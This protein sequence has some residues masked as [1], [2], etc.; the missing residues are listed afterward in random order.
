MNWMRQFGSLKL[1]IKFTLVIILF[2]VIPIGV[3]ASVL[4]YNM[5]QNVIDEN[6]NYMQYT[7]E[8]NKDALSTKMDS[9]NMST[10]LF[11]SDSALLDILKNTQEGKKYSAEEWYALKS[12]DITSLERLVNNNPLLYGVRVYATND[13]IQEVMPVLYNSS[14]MKKQVWAKADDPSGWHFNYT[15]NLFSSYTMDQNRKI[16]SLVTQIDDRNYETIGTI[17]AA[18]TMENMFPSLYEVI[19]NEW[20]CFADADGSYYFGDETQE[21]PELLEDVMHIVD[22]DDNIQTSYVKIKGKNLV[23]S[24]FYVRELDGMLVCVRDITKNVHG[25]YYQRNMFVFI[26][27]VF[28]IVLAFFINAIVKHMLKKLYEI[29]RGI[30]CVQGGDLDVVIEDCGN[31]EMGELGTQINKMLSR[32]K[33]LMEDNLS[34]EMLAKNS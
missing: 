6:V 8:R 31:D 23:V 1:N 7:M 13:N 15:D 16:V 4:F 19:E 29:L 3:L 20:S 27:V 9:I 25:V 18:M 30:R 32:I 17:E 33:E 21:K 22:K 34:R 5:E 11:L 28:L 12:G 24:S 26:M 10:Q 2:M 14:R